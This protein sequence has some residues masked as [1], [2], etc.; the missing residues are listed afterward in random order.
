VNVS[1]EIVVV[2]LA[3]VGAAAYLVRRA[4]N[5]FRRGPCASCGRPPATP[6]NAGLIRTIG[7]RPPTGGA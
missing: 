2:V 4:V 3:V 5:R 6:P 7:D 1:W